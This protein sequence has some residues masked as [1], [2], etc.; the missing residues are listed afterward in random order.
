MSCSSSGGRQRS[1]RGARAGHRALQDYL[2]DK[3]Y[4]TGLANTPFFHGVRDSV[5]GI[6][7]SINCICISKRRGWSAKAW[8]SL[9]GTYQA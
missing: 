5:K 7:S 9:P 2:A 1:Q 4:V 3:L 6:R 8:A